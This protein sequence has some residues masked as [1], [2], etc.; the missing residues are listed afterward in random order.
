MRL[1]GKYTIVKSNECNFH[2]IDVMSP[3]WTWLIIVLKI[4]KMMWCE[5]TFR[6]MV[7]KIISFSM[8]LPQWI[9]DVRYI[10]ITTNV[11][12]R[13]L[14]LY[15]H[16]LR[17]I[18]IFHTCSRISTTCG[19]TC[20]LRLGVFITTKLRLSQTVAETAGAEMIWGKLCLAIETT[21]YNLPFVYVIWK[22]WPMT[23][24]IP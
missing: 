5:R 17:A 4:D 18:M 24:G 10:T 3:K 1:F 20:T 2:G 7:K 19:I 8:C 15:S 12:G 22:W 14:V 11:R 13:V 16:F 21:F 6:I 23:F 9:E